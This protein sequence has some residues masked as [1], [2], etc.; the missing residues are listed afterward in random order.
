MLKIRYR[1]MALVM[2]LAVLFSVL[3]PMEEVQAAETGRVSI[4]AKYDYKMAFEVLNEVNK[5]RTASGAQPLTMDKELLDAAMFRA[6]EISVFFQHVRPN[7]EDCFSVSELMM[8]ENIAAGQRTSAQVM[9]GW[10]NSPGHRAN[11]LDKSYNS[12]GI[13]MA[14]VDDQYY[15][16]QCFGTKLSGA[17]LKGSYSN[18]T[19]TRDIVFDGALVPVKLICSPSS[20]EAGKTAKAL[21]V[22]GDGYFSTTG[23][24][25]GFTFKSSNEGVC[26]VN[27]NGVIKGVGAGTAKISILSGSS[28]V[29]S[30]KIKVSGSIKT[31]SGSAAPKKTGIVKLTS[32]KKKIKVSWKRQLAGKPGYQI[33][34]STSSKFKS[35]KKT[36]TISNN[37]TTSK[38]ITKLKSRKKYYVRIRTYKTVKGKKVYSAWSKVKSIKTK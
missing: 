24:P 5:Q 8:G 12:I 26:T 23:T 10:M 37:K 30:A 14:V 33:Q 17:A 2:T 22:C 20:V 31:A 29:S 3:I 21:L 35:G 1:I 9:K 28:V 13:G 11:I 15:W 36:K 19:V 4:K 7:G 16:V 34:Y 38:T 32:G 18:R 27:S 25:K 6:H